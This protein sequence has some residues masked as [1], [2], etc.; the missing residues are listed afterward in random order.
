M[1]SESVR[2][3]TKTTGNRFLATAT[4][5][6]ESFLA[7]WLQRRILLSSLSQKNVCHTTYVAG[8]T[9]ARRGQTVASVS[10]QL[11]L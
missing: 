10:E 5:P 1:P 2:P 6:G 9:S 3:S 8:E 4:Y 11:K 7:A